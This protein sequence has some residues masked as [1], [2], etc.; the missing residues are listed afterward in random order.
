MLLVTHLTPAGRCCRPFTL[1]AWP[2]YA[3]VTVG[4]SHPGAHTSS[5]WRGRVYSLRFF[6][7]FT[8][9][10]RRSGRSAGS[11]DRG[12]RS[13]VCFVT[14]IIAALFA[15][16]S[17][18]IT[19]L[20]AGAEGRRVRAASSLRQNVMTCVRLR[21]RGYDVLDPSAGATMDPFRSP[22]AVDTGRVALIAEKAEPSARAGERHQLVELPL[23]ACA[24]WRSA[25]HQYQTVLSILPARAGRRP[26]LRVPRPRRCSIRSPLVEASSQLAF[27]EPRPRARMPSPQSTSRSTR[28]RRFAE[29]G[30]C[31]GLPRRRSCQ[32]A[33]AVL[34]SIAQSSP[35]Q[36][37]ARPYLALV[38]V[39]DEHIA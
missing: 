22:L 11:G 14:A 28:A 13:G 26:P 8:T 6:L 34:G 4:D 38:Y 16:N 18:A 31:S 19:F 9:A 20:V 33:A 3:Q 7:I 39:V 27:G 23:R 29:H 35:R 5:A 2:I 15:D 12:G 25:S 32:R 36:P 21:P 30:G 10:G 17:L 37:A 1:A 24:G